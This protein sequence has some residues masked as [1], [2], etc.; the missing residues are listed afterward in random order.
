MPPCNRSPPG[1]RARRGNLTPQR[2]SVGAQFIAPLPTGM[3]KSRDSSRPLGLRYPLRM[4]YIWEL[5]QV[6]GHRTL[7]AAGARAIIRNEAG[8]VLMQLRG[9]LKL[10]GLPAGGIELGESV[11]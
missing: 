7:I 5:R 10:W 6:V 1:E 2:A 3:R 8:D 4:D 11:W 9:D